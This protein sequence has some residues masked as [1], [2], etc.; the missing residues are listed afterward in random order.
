MF[1]SEYI[2]VGLEGNPIF[3]YNH[4]KGPAAVIGGYVYRALSIKNLTGRYLFADIFSK[5]DLKCNHIPVL[6]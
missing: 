1:Y 4:S 2:H 3:T 5:Y 6:F